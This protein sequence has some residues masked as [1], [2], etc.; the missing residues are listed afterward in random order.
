MGTL[1]RHMREAVLDDT[2]W[3]APKIF[4]ATLHGRT[5]WARVRRDSASNLLSAAGMIILAGHWTDAVETGPCA[6]DSTE[7]DLARRACGLVNW[8][9]V[10]TPCQHV[11][12]L[13]GL[14]CSRTRVGGPTG[15]SH[16]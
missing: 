8:L 5:P 10:G 14:I 13:L 15:A 1:G 3:V 4:S 11:W 2:Q 16:S 9:L 12:G 6:G 7:K